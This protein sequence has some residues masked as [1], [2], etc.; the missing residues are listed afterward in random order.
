VENNTASTVSI[1]AVSIS[2]TNASN[3]SLDGTTPAFPIDLA[4]GRT[5]NFTI[6]F[7]QLMPNTYN[8]TVTIET[9]LNNISF[10]VVAMAIDPAA[11][12]LIH[13][14]FKAQELLVH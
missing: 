1:T 6:D 13:M 10:D 11:V 2:G 12:T 14:L 8:A 4:T 9:S 3:F 7:H 5:E